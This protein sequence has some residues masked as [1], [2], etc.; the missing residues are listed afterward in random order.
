M[1][2]KEKSLTSV[3]CLFCLRGKLLCVSSW[4]SF[5]NVRF[6]SLGQ[7]HLHSWDFQLR[8]GRVVGLC[9]FVC[10]V[11]LWAYELSLEERWVALPCTTRN[12]LALHLDFFHG[13]SQFVLHLLGYSVEEGTG[14]RTCTWLV[15]CFNCTCLAFWIWNCNL[16]SVSEY[17]LGEYSMYCLVRHLCVNRSFL[18]PPILQTRGSRHLVLRLPSWHHLP[19]GKFATLNSGDL[20]LLFL[21]S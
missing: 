18:Q 8:I 17:F 20:K 7:S 11:S 4:E 6:L 2:K 10:C 19:P 13:I 9:P 15:N 1:W 16:P 21:L 5:S 3:Y 12:S 14:F